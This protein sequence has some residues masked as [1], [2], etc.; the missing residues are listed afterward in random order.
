MAA[1]SASRM[2]TTEW[3]LLL[4]LSVLWGGSFFFYKI[5]V[6]T[7]PPFTV[8]LGR[9]GLAALALNL[10]LVA[11]RDPMPR[12]AG[13][14]GAFAVMGVLNNAVPFTLI[15]YGETHISSGL[16]SIL[17]ATTPIFTVLTAHVL[18]SNEKLS[19]G[20]ML[21]V[22]L[23][24][25]GVAVL[26]GPEALHGLGKAGLRGEAACLLA[27]LAY[28]FAAIHGR[29]FKGIAPMKVATGQLT[30][31]TA[32]LVPLSLAVDRPWTLPAPS[33]DT[34][35]AFVAFALLCTAFAY[36]I[37]F[38]ILASAGATNV[39]LVT[40]LVPVTALLLGALVLGERVS[41]GSLLGMALIG[42]GLVAV[43]GRLLSAPLR[44]RR[45]A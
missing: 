10:F 38:R 12:R 34:W 42:L 29:R 1:S 14:W 35:L 32:V 18:T 45:V 31:S 39:L 3:L 30:A 21:G 2:G 40:L 6:A 7:L 19:A 5:L 28:A 37:Y 27:A 26:V 24:L 17:N 43:D 41:G 23:G 33:L 4:T 20:K 11:R 44:R 36:M 25:A 9:V 16:A 8:V 13:L 15:A 22:V